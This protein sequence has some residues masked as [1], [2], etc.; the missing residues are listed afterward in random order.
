VIFV[1]LRGRAGHERAV[2]Q[3]DGVVHLAQLLEGDLVEHED[4]WKHEECDGVES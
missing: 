4:P 2:A 3:A 1:S